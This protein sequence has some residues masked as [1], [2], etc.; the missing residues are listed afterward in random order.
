MTKQDSEL[1]M[2]LEEPALREAPGD[3]YDTIYQGLEEGTPAGLP[4]GFG[5]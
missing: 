1:T 3:H 4:A 5:A 2:G